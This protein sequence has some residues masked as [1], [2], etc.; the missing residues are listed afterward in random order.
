MVDRYNCYGWDIRRGEMRLEQDGQWVRHSDYATLEAQ[1]AERMVELRE[2]RKAI[3]STHRRRV[4]HE[5]CEITNC[6]ICDGG[7]F[8]C[9][10]CGAAEIETEQMVCTALSAVEAT[11]PAP[12]VTET[13]LPQDVID[14]VI[15]AREFWDANDDL[16]PE[17]RALDSA[18]EEFSSRVPYADEP[19]TITAAQEAGKP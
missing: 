7:L 11:P 9:A 12:K 2:A 6:P 3:S 10:D 8:Q 15:A 4:K 19:D 17:S 5:N 1:L 18:L 14:L 13:A 16:S